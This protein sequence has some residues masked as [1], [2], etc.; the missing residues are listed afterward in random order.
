M[1]DIQIDRWIKSFELYQFDKLTFQPLFKRALLILQD[2]WLRCLKD[3]IDHFTKAYYLALSSSGV[4]K[5]LSADDDEQDDEVNESSDEVHE[6]AE[7]PKSSVSVGRVPTRVHSPD[8]QLSVANNMIYVKRPWLI[9]FISS[10]TSDRKQRFLEALE[11]AMTDEERQRLRL[12]RRERL[13][14]I[15]ENRKKAAKAAK[16]RR[17]RLAK[18]KEKQLSSPDKTSQQS[19]NEIPLYIDRILPY[20][21]GLM[22]S[23]DFLRLISGDL[24]RFAKT[25]KTAIQSFDQKL[26]L[27]IEVAK[28]RKFIRNYFSIRNR[29]MN[30]DRTFVSVVRSTQQL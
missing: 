17:K 1:P 4:E 10:A 20:K 26:N 22:Q 28:V 19:R 18:E 8:T 16:E 23:K 12:E 6:D 3:D 13:R 7:K 15:Q 14:R 25:Q 11:N 5:D 30:N 9:R 2:S 21:I 27:L 29:L 24:Q